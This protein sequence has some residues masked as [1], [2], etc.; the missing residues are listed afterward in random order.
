M[1]KPEVLVFA[2][3]YPFSVVTFT[4]FSN[5]YLTHQEE[6]EGNPA[7]GESNID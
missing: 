4:L 5:L 6:V 2:D 7:M 3:D 1:I